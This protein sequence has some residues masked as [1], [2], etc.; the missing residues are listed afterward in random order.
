MKKI[1]WLAAV[2]LLLMVAGVSF[3]QD[4][5]T[6]PIRLI[7]PSGP[8]GGLDLIGRSI[9]ARIGDGLGKPVIVENKPGGGG[10]IATEMVAKAKPDG[11]TLLMASATYVVRAGMFKVP[12]DPIRDFAPVTQIAAAPYAIVVNASLPV[13]TVPEF[14]AYAKANPGKI[15]F[16][17]QG[18]GSL[19]HLVGEMIKANCGIDMIHVPYKGAGAAFTDLLANQVQLGI[20][21]LPS[22]MPYTKSDKLRPL[23]VTSR[24]RAKAIPELPTMIEGGVK[25]FA[26]TQWHAVL[27]PK[28]TPRPIVERLNREILKVLQQDSATKYL[29][30]EGAEIVGSSPE[31]LEAH[32]KTEYEK[33]GKLIKQIGLRKE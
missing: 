6:R 27:A 32:I 21:T 20:L 10:D 7:V 17:S 2:A 25:D 23:A 3:A 24:E 16:G 26:V 5:P 1:F 14:I 11:Y 13:K 29:A 19:V 18:N 33:W 28:D 8:G 4:Y 22:A 31:Q 30:N 9:V 15:N 12:Y